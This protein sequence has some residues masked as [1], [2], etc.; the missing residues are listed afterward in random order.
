VGIKPTSSYDA[1][2][3][4]ADIAQNQFY[5]DAL[6]M[7]DEVRETVPLLIFF[8]VFYKQKV[9][10]TLS[11][12]VRT[13]KLLCIPTIRRSYEISKKFQAFI[14][15]LVVVLVHKFLLPSV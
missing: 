13:R 4:S 15:S 1:D 5:L 6:T 7:L 11:A 8:T 3:K 9:I 2:D 12:K 14:K 10:A